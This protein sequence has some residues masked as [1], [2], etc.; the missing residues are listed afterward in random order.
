MPITIIF[1]EEDLFSPSASWG[2]TNWFVQQ[3]EGRGDEG[4]DSLNVYVHGAQVFMCV[5]VFKYMCIYVYVCTYTIICVYV[6]VCVCRLMH[7]TW[8]LWC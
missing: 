4:A 8:L 1:R 3:A 2:V 7:R 6:R 5:S